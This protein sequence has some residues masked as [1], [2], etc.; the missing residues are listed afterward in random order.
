MQTF[1]FQNARLW[2]LVDK[3]P[4]TN[5]TTNCEVFYN[6]GNTMLQKENL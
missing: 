6:N 3:A 2:I 5:T 4:S 1:C